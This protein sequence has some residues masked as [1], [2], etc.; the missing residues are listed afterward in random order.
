TSS[1]CPNFES[2]VR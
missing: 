2:L 1:G